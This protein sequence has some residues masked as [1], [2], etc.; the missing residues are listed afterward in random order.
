MN[1]EEILKRYKDVNETDEGEQYIKSNAR[2]YGEIGL[3]TFFIFL[4]VYK[5]WKGIP[6]HDT[7]AVFWGYIGVGYI[8]NYKFLKTKKTLFTAVCGIVAA[9]SFTIAYIFQTW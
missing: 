1:R 8:Y 4:T 9:I 6:T 5:M 7:L 3:C 2:R